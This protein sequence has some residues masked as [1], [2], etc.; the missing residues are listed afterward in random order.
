MADPT[1]DVMPARGSVPY[2]VSVYVDLG[3]ECSRVHT[4]QCHDERE[5]RNFAVNTLLNTYMQVIY[6]HRDGSGRRLFWC[7]LIPGR[8]VDGQWEPDPGAG[9]EVDIAY[10]DGEYG[11]ITFDLAASV[12]RW[13]PLQVASHG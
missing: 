7:E 3:D 1:N 9:G 5:A 10:I 2:R 12:R 8:W 4:E 11:A 6:P 13:R